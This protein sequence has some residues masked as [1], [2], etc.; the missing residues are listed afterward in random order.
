MRIA[1]DSQIFTLQIYGGVSRY[2]TR[3]ASELDEQQQDVRIFAPV[4]LNK[5][6][7]NIHPETLSG[8]H[9]SLKIRGTLPLLRYINFNF[10]KAKIAAWKPQIMH[11]TYYATRPISPTNV[12]CV[13]TLHDMIHE[14]MPHHFKANDRTS[15]TKMKALDRADHIICV[16]ENS[17]RDLLELTSVPYS[18]T[19]VVHLGFDSPESCHLT[20]ERSPYKHP[21]RPYILYVGKREG[22]KNFKFLIESFSQSTILRKELDIVAFGSHPFTHQE[23]KLMGT[24]GL[25]LDQVQ[26]HTGDD[27]SL[28]S[29]YRHASAFVYPSLY[30][31]F[32][33]PPLE[34]MANDCPVVSSRAGSMPEVLG[35][36]AE[37]FDPTDYHQ[38]STAIEIVVFSASRRN[39]LVRLG[40]ERLKNYSWKRCAEETLEVYRELL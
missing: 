31:G 19:S 39:D 38:L 18:K 9:L 33:I 28:R 13:V 21:S 16:S 4:Y 27:A 7:N 29:F 10:S 11:E 24:L 32:G 15:H 23:I 6:L 12:P 14:K 40:Q 26:H 25:K 5:H 20:H 35:E 22:Y 34:A 2:I 37:F 1:F 8:I 17:R 30:E 3:L 36:A